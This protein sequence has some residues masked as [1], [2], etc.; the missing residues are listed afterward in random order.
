M[1]RYLQAGLVLSYVLLTIVAF[2]LVLQLS[3]VFVPVVAGWLVILAWLAFCF[4]STAAVTGIY[5]FRHGKLRKPVLEEEE[6]LHRCWEEVLQRASCERK[7]RLM[8]E[9]ETDMGAF[10]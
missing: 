8:I 4:L 6:K 10:A 2:L 3:G 7:F 1:S 5:L 9:E